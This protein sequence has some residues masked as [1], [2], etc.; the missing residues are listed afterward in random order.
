VGVTKIEL[1]K[2]EKPLIG[3]AKWFFRIKVKSI[4]DRWEIVAQSEGY[5]RRLDAKTTA[6]HLR[7]NLHE[8]GEVRDA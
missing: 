4:G 3:R 1:F 6:E 7:D 2:G 8:A 5:S